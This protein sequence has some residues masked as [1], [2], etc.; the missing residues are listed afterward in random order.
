MGMGSQLIISTEDMLTYLA[1]LYESYPGGTYLE[2]TN[3][4]EVLIYN[5][6]HEFIGK[7]NDFIYSDNEYLN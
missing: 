5:H 4:G 6:E 2:F 3:D 7:L 1:M